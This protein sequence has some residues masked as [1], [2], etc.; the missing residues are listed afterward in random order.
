MSEKGTVFFPEPMLEATP[1][2]Y[3]LEGY[4]DVFFPA[5]DGTRLHGWL[6]DGADHRAVLLWFHGNAGNI[7]HRLDNLSMLHQTL[8]LPIFIFDYREFGLSEGSISKAGTF[9]D[10]QGAYRYLTHDRGF[11]PSSI[12]LFGRS[13][14]TALAVYIASRK[15]SL[16]VVLESAFTSTADMMS[17]YSP[18]YKPATA[19]PSKYDSLSIIRL[20]RSPLL[21]IHGQMDHTIPISMAKRLYNES[22]APKFFYEVP[23]ADHNDTYIVGGAKYFQ[24][25]KQFLQ[26]CLERRPGALLE[27]DFVV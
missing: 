16:G 15:D 27:T 12:V 2:D 10:A 3:G 21:F 9:L 22:R 11:H 1:K 20:I 14:G 26:K 5:T 6:V 19:G 8:K 18:F 17:L 7:S 23:K 25:W 4:E 13:L 24:I